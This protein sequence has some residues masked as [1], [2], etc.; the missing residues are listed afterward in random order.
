MMTEL[1]NDIEKMEERFPLLGDTET[2]SLDDITPLIEETPNKGFKEKVKMSVDI[3]FTVKEMPDG[4]HIVRGEV[5][6][7]SRKDYSLLENGFIP[8]VTKAG[9][10]LFE[11]VPNTQSMFLQ[12]TSAERKP[13]QFESQKLYGALVN[14]NVIENHK[15]AVHVK[16]TKINLAGAEGRNFYTLDVVARIDFPTKTNATD[17]QETIGG[18]EDNVEKAIEAPIPTVHQQPA[19]NEDMPY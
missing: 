9:L 13:R 17:E 1:L 5:T 8:H 4:N 19:I 11:I 6:D 3:K 18:Q 7:K 14:C 16:L 15:E 12:H 2:I 10:V